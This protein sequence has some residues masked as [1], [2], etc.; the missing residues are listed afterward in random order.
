VH[1]PEAILVLTEKRSAP[2]AEGA[3][4]QGA[5]LVAL[6]LLPRGTRD[7]NRVPSFPLSTRRAW[8]QCC[9]RE[10]TKSS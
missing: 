5:C 2:Q 1:C 4:V 9:E 10:G 8:G 7:T 6:R 3:R